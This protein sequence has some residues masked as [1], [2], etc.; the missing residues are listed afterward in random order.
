MGWAIAL[1]LGWPV[2]AGVVI[3]L[4]HVGTKRRERSP[5]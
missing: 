1:F 4:V 2:A 5:L 3:A